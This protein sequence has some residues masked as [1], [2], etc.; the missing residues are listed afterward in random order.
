MGIFNSFSTINQINT[1]L[2]DLENQITITRDMVMRDASK[3]ELERCLN[4][5]K[6]MHQNLINTFSQ[7]STAMAAS[8]TIYN[9]KMTMPEILTYSKNVIMNLAVII[10]KMD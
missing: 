6:K 1:Q 7:S 3:M 2:K 10:A 9:C 4:L 5:L 8:Y